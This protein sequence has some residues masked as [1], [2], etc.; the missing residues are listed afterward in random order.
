MLAVGG[1][2]DRARR[3]RVRVWRESMVLCRLK[4][5]PSLNLKLVFQCWF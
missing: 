4:G 1:M 5:D 3:E 2:R